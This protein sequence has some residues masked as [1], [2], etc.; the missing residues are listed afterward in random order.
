VVGLWVGAAGCGDQVFVGED[1][2]FAFAITEDT[3]PFVMAEDAALYRV[4]ERIELPLR[5][6]SND[7][8]RAAREQAQAMD[9][10]PY[11]RVPWVQRHDYELEIDW[12]LINLDDETRRV[13]LML[14]GFNEFHE[15]SPGFVIDDDEIIA[16]FAQWERLMELDPLERRTGTIR[17]EELD[18]IAVDLATVISAPNANQ[19]VHPNNHSATDP[20]SMPFIPE[21]VPAL[22]G[23]RAGL[24]SEGTGN[25]V[26][27]LTVRVRD[28][29]GILVRESEAW[30]QPEPQLFVPA[31][32]EE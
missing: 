26:L 4:E 6:Q 30:D 14:N 11:R 22:H 24:Q 20:R 10:Y 17:E 2:F 7:E 16:D 27:E 1:G 29:R 15:Y 25:I 8:R 28:E 12:V 23:I 18:E 9:G 13:T 32:Q 3:P 31:P 19:V 21:I 5:E